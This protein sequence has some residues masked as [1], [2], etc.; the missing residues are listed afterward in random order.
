[1]DYYGDLPYTQEKETF[2]YLYVLLQGFPNVLLVAGTEHDWR[3]SHLSHTKNVHSSVLGKDGSGAFTGKK[4]TREMKKSNN[5]NN[6][7]EKSN[8]KK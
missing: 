5:N 7:N 4:I 3:P 2:R 6:K 1:M 8:N